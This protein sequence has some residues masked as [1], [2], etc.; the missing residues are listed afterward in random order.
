M[1]KQIHTGM[2][3][4]TSTEQLWKPRVVDFELFKESTYGNKVVKKNSGHN[5]RDTMKLV[6]D[7]QVI[8]LFH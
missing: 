8:R 6:A 4:W 3:I 1:T 2:L 7:D 5:V